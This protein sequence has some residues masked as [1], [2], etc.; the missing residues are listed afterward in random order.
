[1][2]PFSLKLGSQSNGSRYTVMRSV[3]EQISKVA[4]LKA[5]E[6][7]GSQARSPVALE[8]FE[9]GHNG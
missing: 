2:L 5:P 9:Y 3:T 1:M 6:L 8:Q 7:S 4:M